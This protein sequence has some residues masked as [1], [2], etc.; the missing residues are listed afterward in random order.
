[1]RRFRLLLI[2]I[3]ITGSASLHSQDLAIPNLGQEDIASHLMD[4]VAPVYPANAQAAQVQGDVIVKVEISPGGSIWSA[5]VISGPP[6]LRQA[7]L[8]AVKKWRYQPFHSSPGTSITV[9]GNVVVSFTLQG[10]PAVHTPHESTATGSYSTIVT[11]PPRDN[12]GQ[13]D[14]EIANRFDP[15]WEICTRGVIAHTTD[16]ATAEACKNAASIADEFTLDSRA[17]E[18]R[19]AYVYAATAFANVHDLETALRYAERA[20]EVLKLGHDDNSGSE[21][22]YSIR[23]QLRAFS[24]DL[25]G[26]DED[27]SIAEDFCRKGQISWALKRDLQFHAELLNRMNRT[28]EA[29]AKLD[30]A[31]KL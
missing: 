21:S 6:M 3:L 12:S 20:V 17:V 23:G 15:V 14:A 10:K 16:I 8:D 31:A 27:M 5:T 29:Q 26:G 28:R 9:T 18:R 19:R 11:F 24:G 2:T 7:S 25:K 30:E 13:P 22:A 4:Y 1:M